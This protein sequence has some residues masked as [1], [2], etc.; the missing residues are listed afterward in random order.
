MQDLLNQIDDQLL[1][2]L[3]EA[4]EAH[5]EP[6]PY[7]WVLLAFTALSIALSFT[8]IWCTIRISKNQNNIA[9]FEKRIEVVSALEE[10]KL[11][12]DILNTTKDDKIINDTEEIIK[13]L[14]ENTKPYQIINK[15]LSNSLY[16][17]P[18][19]IS[20]K[21]T[22]IGA[23]YLFI[24]LNLKDM[25]KSENESQKIELWKETKEHIKYILDKFNKE[26]ILDDISKKVYLG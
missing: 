16:L 18:D 24:D 19:I 9:L 11:I 10:I 15:Q 13:E 12:C 3:I 17:F 14:N 25:I 22:M 2:K 6:R 21:V 23:K 20:A 26:N 7:D 5:A 4:I 8:A 1:Q